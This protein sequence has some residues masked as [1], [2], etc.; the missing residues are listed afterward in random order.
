MASQA[1][2][3]MDAPSREI[4]SR[5]VVAAQTRG[6]R[7]VLFPPEEVRARVKRGKPRKLPGLD[8]GGV[9]R[10]E[11]PGRGRRSSTECAKAFLRG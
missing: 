6:G 11:A 5:I 2:D 4:A 9:E 1:R 10:G 7:V 8:L 3:K